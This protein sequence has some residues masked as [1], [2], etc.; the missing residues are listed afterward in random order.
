MMAKASKQTFRDLL[1][2][3]RDEYRAGLELLEADLE[4]L[5]KM[6][7]SDSLVAAGTRLAIA[8]RKMQIESVNL[9]LEEV[10]Q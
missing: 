6:G 2:A 3:K 1:R 7:A 5:E 8:W 10:K 4:T 9:L